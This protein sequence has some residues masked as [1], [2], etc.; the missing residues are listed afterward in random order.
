MTVQKTTTRP[1][2]HPKPKPASTSHTA[3]THAPK[4]NKPAPHT[5]PEQLAAA[6]KWT[7][8]AFKDAYGRAPTASE[9]AATVKRFETLTHAG[10]HAWAAGATIINELKA[11]PEFKAKNPHA[12]EVEAM[13]RNLHKTDATLDD[14]RQARNLIAQ[15]EKGGGK[16][17]DAL[18]FLGGLMR[19]QP[20]YTQAHPLGPM[21]DKL[22]SDGLGRSPSAQELKR[23]ED[24]I[25]KTARGANAGLKGIFKAGQALE[26]MVRG[27][28]EFKRHNPLAPMFSQIYKTN[29]GRQPTLSEIG[30]ATRLANDLAKDG[31]NIFEIG[32]TLQFFIRAG[33]EYKRRTALP[34][35]SSP[36]SP[37]IGRG[38]YLLGRGAEALRGLAK[39]V[40][41]AF[42]WSQNHFNAWDALI[43]AESGWNPNAQNPTS[44][45]Y[46]LGQ[47]LNS[48]WRS[49]GPKTS[50][51]GKQLEYMAR[52]IRD[53]YGDPVK[54]L[55]FHANK[56]WY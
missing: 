1:A 32:K 44:T 12:A 56:H 5:K 25:A 2:V 16:A 13:Y 45:A 23:C 30:D 22:F 42:G 29:L 8:E 52:Y 21:V 4:S 53:R 37:Y 50:D 20:Q 46:G 26:R 36:S 27:S 47:F 48:T 33:D 54:A 3:A 31:R 43:N 28:P 10:K 40:A 11:T 9:L 51:P 49:F 24:F 19:N 55:A 38:N 15:V 7:T 14:H 6:R 34:S 18:K 41:G 39:S 17:K 35:G